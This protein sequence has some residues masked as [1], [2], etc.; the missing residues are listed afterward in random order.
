MGRRPRR[1]TAKLRRGRRTCMRLRKG[2]TSLVLLDL[3]QGVTHWGHERRAE[4][5]EVGALDRE[6]EEEGRQP[7]AFEAQA[8][9]DRDE[10]LG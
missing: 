2:L 10:E 7:G 8:D 1:F 9:L 3:L 6:V 5:A 4:A